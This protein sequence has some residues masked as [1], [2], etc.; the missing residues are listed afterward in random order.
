MDKAIN[1]LTREL[2][3]IKAYMHFPHGKNSPL[4]NS[5]LIENLLFDNK[6]KMKQIILLKQE[7]DICF[8]NTVIE[9]KGPFLI[10]LLL[11][12]TVNTLFSFSR[13]RFDKRLH[14]YSQ[15]VNIKHIFSF[16]TFCYKT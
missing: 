12:N 1:A 15:R 11:A 10:R 16:A 3:H 4:V 2:M 6:V 7:N 14:L 5:S 8:I 13:T 9:L